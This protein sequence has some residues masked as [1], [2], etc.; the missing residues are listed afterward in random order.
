MTTTPTSRRVLSAVAAGVAGAA[1]YATPDFIAAR[2]ARAWTKTGIGTLLLAASVPDFLE[3]RDELRATKALEQ[4]T[5]QQEAAD[6]DTPA[7]DEPSTISTRGKVAV[8]G[9]VVA[10]LAVSAVPLV[11]LEKWIYR[12]GEARAAAGR[13]YAHTRPALVYGALTAAAALLTSPATTD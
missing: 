3:L 9:A 13:S 10:V 12:R 2:S 1:Y 8:G 11:L 4:A 7:Q 5:V 6:D